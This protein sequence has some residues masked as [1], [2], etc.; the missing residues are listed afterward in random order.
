MF[1]H[2]KFSKRLSEAIC[3]PTNQLPANENTESPYRQPESYPSKG[4]TPDEPRDP[5]YGYEDKKNLLTCAGPESLEY[6]LLTV[7]VCIPGMLKTKPVRIISAKLL[8]R[9]QRRSTAARQ[10]AR[11]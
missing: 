9:Y 1:T 3:E 4:G 5:C 8:T 11:I 2:H 6:G 10:G 7:A